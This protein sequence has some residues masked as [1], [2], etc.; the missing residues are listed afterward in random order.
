ME[1][2]FCF[3]VISMGGIYLWLIYRSKVFRWLLL[4]LDV[5]FNCVCFLFIEYIMC[6]Y[7]FFCS[8]IS[9][10]FINICWLIVLLIYYYKVSFFVVVL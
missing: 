3:I 2:L 4:C 9:V 1:M 7:I 6:W 8:F 10:L 5:V